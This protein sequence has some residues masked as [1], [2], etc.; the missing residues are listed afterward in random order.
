M[1]KGL[2]SSSGSG[3]KYLTN[4]VFSV[5]ILGS[6]RYTKTEERK[7]CLDRC[8]RTPFPSHHNMLNHSTY[9]TKTGMVQNKKNPDFVRVLF[10][11]KKIAEETT[12]RILCLPGRYCSGSPLLHFHQNQR[13]PMH[14][15]HVPPR[16]PADAEG[17]P[18]G[19]EGHGVVLAKITRVSTLSQRCRH[20]ILAL[21]GP[22]NQF[23]LREQRSQ[24][25]LEQTVGRS[26]GVVENQCSGPQVL[27]HLHESH[28]DLP[29]RCEL[30][31]ENRRPQSGCQIRVQILLVHVDGDE[32]EFQ[33][34]S[35]FTTSA[36]ETLP[37]FEFEHQDK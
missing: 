23:R 24:M 36:H 9:Y 7:N 8:P 20:E 25:H 29:E 14:L 15:G 33:C 18:L 1:K 6:H 12:G 28:G 21:P 2:L 4:S 37:L 19:F 27:R 5:I 3:D 32:P 11:L 30:S 34:Q 26:V 35:F 16:E 31:L 22:R 10:C 17:M 13:H